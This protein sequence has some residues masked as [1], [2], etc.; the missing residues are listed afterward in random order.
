MPDY[1]I[2]KLL[3][4]ITLI[5]VV[6]ISLYTDL[7]ERRIYNKVL[8]PGF[9]IGVVLNVLNSGWSG[10][11][12]SLW[13]FLLG[14]GILLIPF[15]KGGIGGGDVKLLGTIGA[16]AGWEFVGITALGAGV[17]GGLIAIGILLYEKRLG[18][19]I[20]EFLKGS[21]ILVGSRFKIIS[22]NV[23]E[24]RTMFPYGVAITLGVLAAAV[25]E[26]I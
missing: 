21:W 17:F 8:L 4:H 11:T 22:F 15:L 16:I 6:G 7:V 5:L 20:V 9:L 14:F 2:F 24:K 10:L 13:G 12:F 18:K 19:V 3:S 25:V 26:K 23:D 1:L